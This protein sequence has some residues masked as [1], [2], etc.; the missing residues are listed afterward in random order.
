MDKTLNLNM[1][2]YAVNRMYYIVGFKSCQEICEF[3]TK[4][5]SCDVKCWLLT[6]AAGSEDFSHDRSW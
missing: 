3:W 1:Q 6:V 5:G 4:S 2:P